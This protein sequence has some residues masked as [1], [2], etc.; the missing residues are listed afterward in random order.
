MREAL[1]IR[2]ELVKLQERGTPVKSPSEALSF[3]YSRN[4][5]LDPPLPRTPESVSVKGPKQFLS[6]AYVRRD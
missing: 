3:R 5:L 2:R 1:C 4:P 6:L